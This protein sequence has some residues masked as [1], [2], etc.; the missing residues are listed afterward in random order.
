LRS[1]VKTEDRLRYQAYK[2]Y[3]IITKMKILKAAIFDWGDTIMR[4]LSGFTGPMV[5]WPHV[6]IIDGVKEALETIH[7]ELICCLA[8]NASDSDAVKMGLALER[9]YIR[10][11]F[12][13][14]FTSKELGARKPD[15]AFFKTSLIKWEYHPE[16][17]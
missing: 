8:S 13:Y 16:S 11:Y 17:A 3:I 5:N 12:R 15:I 14:L 7:R 10:R 2:D 1:G 6:E 9:V 4:D